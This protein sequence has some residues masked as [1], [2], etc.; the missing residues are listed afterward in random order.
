MIIQ[1]IKEILKLKETRVYA[2]ERSLML[3]SIYYF[4]KYHKFKIPKFH[5]DWYKDLA[6]ISIK[7]LL[8]VTFRE[9]AK[10]SLAKIKIVHSICYSKNKFIIW[11][12]YDQKKAA[13]NLY[14]VVIELQTN[15]LIIEDFGQLF[16]EETRLEKKSRKKSINEFITSNGYSRYSPCS[17]LKG[18]SFVHFF[19]R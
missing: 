2:C 6:N 3:F 9:S 15:P 4:S 12:S 14:D 13:A 19:I 7:I 18:Y 11:T 10:T 8:L 16:F 5:K 1:K 17:S